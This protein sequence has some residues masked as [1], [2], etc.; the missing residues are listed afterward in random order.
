MTELPPM[1]SRAVRPAN[2]AQALMTAIHYGLIRYSGAASY[3]GDQSHG[4][5]VIGTF[6]PR[7]A[8]EPAG[9]WA[10]RYADYAPL[11]SASAVGVN[12]SRCGRADNRPGLPAYDAVVLIRG[13]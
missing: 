2:R 3:D 5:R 7:V 10:P 11:A 4:N 9:E 12:N 8:S 13:G 1:P 6:R